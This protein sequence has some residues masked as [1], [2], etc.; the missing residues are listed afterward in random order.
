MCAKKRANWSKQKADF[1]SRL[2]GGGGVSSLDDLFAREDRRKDE[3]VLRR[4]SDLRVKACE[5]KNRYA[6]L[7]EAEEALDWCESRGK[8]GLSIYECPYCGG[9]HL[10]SKPR[11]D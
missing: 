3:A 2:G 5:S 7:D 4:E 8:R 10:T 6:H 11:R 9:W 1:N